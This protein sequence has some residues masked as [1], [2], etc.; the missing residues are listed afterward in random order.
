MGLWLA[1]AVGLLGAYYPFAGDVLG[2]ALL[3]VFV[4]ALVI[5]FG[6]RAAAKEPENCA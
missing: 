5:R 3:G 2:G 4:M 6:A 1:V